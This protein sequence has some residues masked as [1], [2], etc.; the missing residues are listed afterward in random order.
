M[1]I[2]RLQPQK[3][4]E[5]RHHRVFN[6][7]H[8]LRILPITFVEGVAGQ[9]FGDLS[10]AVVFSLLASLGVAIYFVPMLAALSSPFKGNNFSAA[11]Q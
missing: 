2:E 7:D 11:S 3:G 6:A 4:F 8:H 1:P 5:S 9:I 10:L